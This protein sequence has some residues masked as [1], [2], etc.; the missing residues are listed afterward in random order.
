MVVAERIRGE[1]ISL[2][3]KEG[4]TAPLNS[5]TRVEF[6][7]SEI[8]YEKPEVI[9][10]GLEDLFVELRKADIGLGRSNSDYRKWMSRDMFAPTLAAKYEFIKRHF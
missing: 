6:K 9:I 3:A 7:R 4:V 8:G 5:M 10:P 2:Q 1:L